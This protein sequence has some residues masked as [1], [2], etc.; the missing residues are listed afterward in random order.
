MPVVFKTLHICS[1]CQCRFDS[2]LS[3]WC[4]EM[5]VLQ[6]GTHYPMI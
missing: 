6:Y 5:C 2:A 4:T 1:V 3:A